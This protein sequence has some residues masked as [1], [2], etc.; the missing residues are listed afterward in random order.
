MEAIY[1][2]YEKIWFLKKSY[3]KKY[4]INVLIKMSI[5]EF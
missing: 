4:V 3:S 2:F 5:I 1:E